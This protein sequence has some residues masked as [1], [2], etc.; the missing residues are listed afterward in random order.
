MRKLN[1]LKAIV[2]FVW[3]T[4]LIGFPLLFFILVLM[5]FKNEAID[6]DFKL[7]STPIDL[8]T[9]HSKY[10]PFVGFFYA[11]ILMYMLFIFRK[12]LLNFQKLK[13]FENENAY[14]LRKIGNLLLI[15]ALIYFLVEFSLQ[16]LVDKIKIQ[17]GFGPFIYLISLG[18]F[19][20]VL[21]EVFKMGKKIKEENELTI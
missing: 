13:I 20:H 11:G 6:F 18:L 8:T 5:F 1:V 21:A 12:L 16:L 9:K 3:I 15:E 14:L 17:I 19:F 10:L 7:N 4:S 2:D